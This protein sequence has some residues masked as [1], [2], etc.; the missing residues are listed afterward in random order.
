MLPQRVHGVDRGEALAILDRVAAA[1][2]AVR[3]KPGLYYAA[4]ELQRV[5]A[6]IVELAGERGWITLPELRDSLGT[7][8]KYAQAVLEHLDACGVTA[9]HGDR[10]VLRRRALVR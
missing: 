5:R 3:V 6:R 9:R 2:R 8:R 10:H 4:G 1:G 7:S